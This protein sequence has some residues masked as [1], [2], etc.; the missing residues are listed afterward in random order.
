[1]QWYNQN[2]IESNNV[3]AASNVE[4]SQDALLEEPSEAVLRRPVRG[5]DEDDLGW[6][7]EDEGGRRRR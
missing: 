1:M 6:E 4:P 3:S 5:E 2:A 7:H